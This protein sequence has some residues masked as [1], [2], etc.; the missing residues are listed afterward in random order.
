MDV[1]LGP[2]LVTGATGR[3]GGSVAN[4]LL[5]RGLPVRVF[6]RDGGAP[7]ARRLHELGAEVAVGNMQNPENLRTAMAGVAGVY[8]MQSWEDGV[9]VEMREGLLVA[10]TAHTRKVDFFVYS[11]AAGVDRDTGVP[12]FESKF[13]IENRIAELH[14]KAAILRP[15]YFMENFLQPAFLSGMQEGVLRF[16]LPPDKPLQVVAVGDI[17]EFAADAFEHPG[18]HTGRTFEIAGDELTPKQI[19]RL[20]GRKLGHE[21]RYE[22]MPLDEYA[23]EEPDRAIMFDWLAKEGYEAPIEALRTLHPELLSFEQWLN[24]ISVPQPAAV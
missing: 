16:P 24:T 9:D 15:V 13:V 10:E 23:R 21:V 19:A 7:Q 20:W 5:Q 4:R 8:S 18:E 6:V 17:G 12:H 3:Q 1:R 11:S 22:Q 2:V 14:L